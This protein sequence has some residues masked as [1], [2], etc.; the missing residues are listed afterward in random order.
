ML[1]FSE[2]TASLFPVPP[3]V[4]WYVFE[5]TDW[6]MLLGKLQKLGTILAH[7]DLYYS[8]AICLFVTYGCFVYHMSAGYLKRPEDGIR[9][10]PGSGVR[11]SWEP[12]CGNQ[13]WLDLLEENLVFLTTKLCLQPFVYFK[14]W[15]MS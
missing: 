15:I 12:L 13:T 4:P 8:F 2:V 3:P 14:A 6:L 9:S 5:W 7:P 11:N 10:H 1:K